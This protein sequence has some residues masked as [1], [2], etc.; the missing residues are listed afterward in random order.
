MKWRGLWPP[1]TLQ[2]WGSE[3][4]VSKWSWQ[5]QSQEMNNL[6]QPCGFQR[7]HLI[8][9]PISYRTMALSHWSQGPCQTC[10]SSLACNDHLCLSPRDLCTLRNV[11][12]IHSE[13]YPSILPK[14]PCKGH[15][16]HRIC[17]PYQE[18]SAIPATPWVALQREPEEQCQQMKPRLCTQRDIKIQGT[19]QVLGSLQERRTQSD[20][21]FRGICVFL[22]FSVS[23]EKFLISINSIFWHFSA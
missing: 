12:L 18:T 22:P 9:S 16:V 2:T 1:L 5:L 15:H 7:C 10:C 21:V 19:F 13:P 14:E 8:W 4:G 17:R 20:W 11:F 6:S 23:Q 3:V